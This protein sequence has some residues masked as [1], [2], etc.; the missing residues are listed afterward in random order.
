ML[1]L[2]DFI[3]IEIGTM[4]IDGILND[5][6]RDKSKGEKQHLESNLRLNETRLALAMHQ[7]ENRL[8]TVAG[9]GEAYKGI[10]DDVKEFE[11]EIASEE[12]Y[13]DSAES[14]AINLLRSCRDDRL[15]TLG[16]RKRLGS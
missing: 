8:L 3:A 4:E 15:E 2:N 5:L 11:E 16:I 9:Y 14:I 6:N 7:N 13:A 10:Q 12:Q 1:A